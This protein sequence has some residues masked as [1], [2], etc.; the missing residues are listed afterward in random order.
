M[1]K[2][3]SGSKKSLNKIDQLESMN[4]SILAAKQ[5]YEN[6]LLK[7]KN[8]ND[9][10]KVAT[11]VKNEV[12]AKSSVKKKLL[13]GSFLQQMKAQKEMLKKQQKTKPKVPNH[14]AF[15][16]DSDDDVK[17]EPAKPKLTVKE[18]INRSRIQAELKEKQAML[19]AQ[20]LATQTPTKSPVSVKAP[21]PRAK[22]SKFSQQAIA[23]PSKF[24]EKPQTKTSKFTEQ[25]ATKTSKFSEQHPAK[26]SKFSEQPPAKS[27]KFSEQPPA[28]SSKFSEQPPTKSSKFSEQPP[29]KS[30]KFS[31]QPPTTSET[32]KSSTDL[33]SSSSEDQPKRKRKNRWGDK[34]EVPP[35][36]GVA[37]I[38]QIGVFNPN[39]SAN[40]FG[41]GTYRSV[42]L[43]GCS[44]L[45]EDQKKQLKEQ[46]ELQEMYQ[47]IMAN[48]QQQLLAAQPTEKK[49]Q[50]KYA[51][52]SDEEIDEKDGT[53]EHIQRRREME[54]TQ[55]LAEKLTDGNE[56]KH[57]IGDFLPPAELEK[58]MET[59]RALKDGR[60]PDYSEYKEF[61]IQCDNLGFKMLQK[62]GWKEGEGLG[63]EGQGITA[64]VNKGKQSL[65]G[66]GVG[67]GGGGELK[68]DD[69]DFDVYRKRMMLAYK[70]RPNPMNNPR[71]PYY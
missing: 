65:D 62:M 4:K 52:D 44:E 53:W 47:M 22:S 24:T 37:N 63:Q 9:K 12:P 14:S 26:S 30:S 6:S 17:N 39:V 31:E 19:N 66:A 45:S 60:T 42:G 56:G 2:G 50:V 71:R 43:V 28:K 8:K 69:T 58:F 10:P 32:K 35:P 15:D 48:K 21:E 29:T 18:K 59:Y 67:V 68:K 16:S 46:K 38:P 41:L 51:Y 70:F 61:K 23:K 49:L 25:P 57:F 3:G 5:K 27:S 33:N 40:N 64:P 7:N 1:Y 34:V 11:P 13:G 55:A 54:K 20:L 36:V